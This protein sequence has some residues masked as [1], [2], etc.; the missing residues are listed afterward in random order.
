MPELF[1]QTAL[2]E[3]RAQGEAGW[4]EEATD[5][6]TLKAKCFSREDWTIQ[7]SLNR[8]AKSTFPRMSFLGLHGALA[9]RDRS[10]IEVIC[11]PGTFVSAPGPTTEVRTCLHQPP[12][13]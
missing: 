11:P 6:G 1:D 4:R 9:S 10:E 5:R 3:I 12:Q 7:I 2:V 8:L 13:T